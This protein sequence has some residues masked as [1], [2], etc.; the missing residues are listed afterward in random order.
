MRES[1]HDPP[2][3]PPHD[4]RTTTAHALDPVDRAETRSLDCMFWSLSTSSVLGDVVQQLTTTPTGLL[5]LSAA[6]IGVLTLALARRRATLAYVVRCHP[7]VSI[8][9]RL[10]TGSEPIFIPLIDPDAA[11]RPRPRAP[12]RRSAR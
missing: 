7:G 2:H 11:R 6:V 3:D 1:A 12:S 4:L 8:L 9:A 5:L 10:N